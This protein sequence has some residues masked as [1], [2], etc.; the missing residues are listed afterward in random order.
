LT[1]VAFYL[2]KQQNRIL[3]H[4]LGDFRGN[5]HYSSMARCKARGRLH[6]SSNGIFFAISYG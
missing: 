3:C 2:Q 4:P 6:I 1:E 5:V